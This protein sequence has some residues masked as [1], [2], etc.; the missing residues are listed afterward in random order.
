VVV[1]AASATTAPTHT[2]VITLLIPLCHHLFRC[3]RTHCFQVHIPYLLL[4]LPLPLPILQVTAVVYGSD[5]E[6]PWS[7]AGAPVVFDW[8]IQCDGHDS[9]P[10]SVLYCSGLLTLH[11]YCTVLRTTITLYYVVL[12]CTVTLTALRSRCTLCTTVQQSM[13]GRS[14]SVTSGVSLPW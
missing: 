10:L 1:R 5:G 2:V 13:A 11:S 12:Y 14:P 6:S 3:T 8:S 9:A 7:F 4:L